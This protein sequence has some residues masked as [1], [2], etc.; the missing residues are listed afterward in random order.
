MTMKEPLC[1]ICDNPLEHYEDYMDY[2]L[3]ESRDECTSCRYLDYY[4]TGGYQVMVGD[5][6]WQWSYATPQEVRA[7]HYAEIDA[8]IAKARK[9]AHDAVTR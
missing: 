3:L 4:L 8:A 5:V 1:P 2:I 9:A 6:L 7:S